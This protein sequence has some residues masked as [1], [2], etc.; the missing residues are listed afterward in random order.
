MLF[1]Q[2]LS[3]LLKVKIVLAITGMLLGSVLT[4]S[5]WAT[6]NVP[7]QVKISHTIASGL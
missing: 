7:D 2:L 5:C 3:K 1:R 6:E 4:C